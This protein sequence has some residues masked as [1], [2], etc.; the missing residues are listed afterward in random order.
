[1]EHR[2]EDNS[3][4]DRGFPQQGI[5]RRKI[6]TRIRKLVGDL[7]GMSR[8]SRTSG[9]G[10]DSCPLRRRFGAHVEFGSVHDISDKFAMHG[11]HNG[12][13]TAMCPELVV[14][15]V[16]MVAECLQADTQRPGDFTRILAI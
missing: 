9:K 10:T 1:M 8:A 4:A 12:L 2:K 5:S 6:Q 7:A 11:M 14:N 3:L 13:K 16:E 15:V